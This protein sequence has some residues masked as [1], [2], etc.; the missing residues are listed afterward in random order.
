MRQNQ[1]RMD[2]DHLAEEL[3][4]LL[5]WPDREIRVSRL[6][7]V[8][9]DLDDAKKAGKS[10]IGAFEWLLAHVANSDLQATAHEV[11]A[12]MSGGDV[13]LADLLTR[14]RQ[15]PAGVMRDAFLDGVV[16]DRVHAGAINDAFALLPLMSRSYERDMAIDIIASELGHDSARRQT[17]LRSLTDQDRQRLQNTVKK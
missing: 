9:H 6:P 15:L 13:P 12:R 3:D 5:T 10:A 4:A 1:Y 17:W 8:V 7:D 11:G 2:Q 14:A 16:Q